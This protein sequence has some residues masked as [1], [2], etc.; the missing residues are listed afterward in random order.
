VA[1]GSVGLVA[2]A[3]A[4]RAALV[5]KRADGSTVRFSGAPRVWCGPWE[6]D[7]ARPSIHVGFPEGF[8]PG[9]DRLWHLSAV[10]RDARVG[11]RIRFPLG[12]VFDHPR[13]AELFVG[14]RPN[15][16]STEADGS[17]GWITFSHVTCRR[18]GVVAFRVSATLGS[19]NGGQPISVSGTF[20]GHVA[21]RP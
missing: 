4:A 8:A 12:F 6:A 18:G 17:S 1:A 21:H 7:V 5:F 11:R 14:D 19:E 3:D 13:G 10:R 9:R 16:A 15:E 2:G 20:R